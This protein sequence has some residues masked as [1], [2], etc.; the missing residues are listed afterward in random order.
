MEKLSEHFLGDVMVTPA[1]TAGQ[2]GV[3]P[4]CHWGC[5]ET[6]G[7]GQIPLLQ[8]SLGSETLNFPMSLSMRF[9]SGPTC[10]WNPWKTTFQR[11]FDD[12]IF[13]GRQRRGSVGQGMLLFSVVKGVDLVNH[14]RL[15]DGQL[16]HR[17]NSIFLLLFLNK[18]TPLK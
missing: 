8:Q 10:L 17:T 11:S 18:K 1:E 6:P 3:S 9:T 14:P 15:L 13:L 16:R 2:C 12:I 4:Q 7:K 5:S